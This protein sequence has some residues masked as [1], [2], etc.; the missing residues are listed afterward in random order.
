L[1]KIRI[2]TALI[3]LPLTLAAVFL[4]PAWLFRI[5]VAILLLVGCSEFRRIADLAPGP[6]W[7]LLALQALILASLLLAWPLP[8]ELAPWLL[9][10]ACV[11]WALLFLRLAG[12]RPDSRPDA[13]F[14]RLGFLS[15]LCALSFGF[16]AMCWLRDQVN[17]ALVV[18]LLFLLIWASDVG[19]YFSGRLLGRHKLAPR[20]SPGKTWEGV[21]GGVALAIAAA[22]LLTG[23]FPGIAL[24]PLP[25]VAIAVVT[26]LA[27]VGGDLFI[28]IH[29]R[30]VA[31]DDTGT[32][33]PGH[34]G[35]LDRYD[36][37]LSGAPFYALTY[38][39]L[40]Q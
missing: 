10:A 20:I 34:G 18:F 15:A 9:A 6:G 28:S 2:L 37:L 7:M 38:T 31:V 8:Q 27:S 40:A 32:F 25:L 14:R 16:F 33:L 23:I 29:K 4:A 5:L 3:I 22:F 30:T 24:G 1:L 26:T 35:V 36:S 21:Y 12:F 13:W 19:A 17:G 39:L 11:T